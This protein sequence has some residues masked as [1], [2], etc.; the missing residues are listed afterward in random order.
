[1]DRVILGVNNCRTAEKSLSWTLLI[2]VVSAL[3]PAKVNHMTLLLPALTN[4]DTYKMQPWRQCWYQ[5]VWQTWVSTCALCF[6]NAL[7]CFVVII[8]SLWWIHGTY[9]LK[10]FLVASLALGYKRSMQLRAQFLGC[11]YSTKLLRLYLQQWC[12]KVQY[13][14]YGLISWACK[15][16]PKWMLQ[17]P[18][19]D[20][21]KLVQVMPCCLLA[22]S[23]YMSHYWPR[24]LL[25][26]DV[27][28]PQDELNH[29]KM[30]CLLN[31]WNITLH[32][33]L[34]LSLCLW[35]V[36]FVF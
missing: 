31:F 34:Y 24:Y 4:P 22:T 14:S 21:S 32:S 19:D 36:S 26:Y 28:R 11:I 3:E 8:S 10:I 12:K 27:T 7:L 5:Y 18:I 29:G 17:K 15:I 6:I 9:V 20:M 33:T 30:G 25:P 16:A 23:H 35:Q 1:M 2:F 13:L